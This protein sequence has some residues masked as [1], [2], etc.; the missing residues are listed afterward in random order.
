MEQPPPDSV[1]AA[2]GGEDAGERAELL[3]V[4]EALADTGGW[5]Y[6]ASTDTLRL[7]RG[8]CRIHGFE[9]DATPTIDEVLSTYRPQDRHG[10][11]R[12][13]ERALVTGAG[14][15]EAA[16]VAAG[17][18]DGRPV[19]IRGETVRE[20]GETVR[21]YGAVRDVTDVESRTRT[22][23]NR[24]AKLRA[25]TSAFP[26]L[27]FLLSDR[28]RI[29]E[30]FSGD[31]GTSL[32]FGE[33]EEVIG[34]TIEDR[35][36]EPTGERIRS[37]IDATLETGDTEAIEYKLERSSRTHWFEARLAPVEGHIEGRDAVAMVTRDVTRR[38]AT[39]DRLR[40]RETHLKT[41]Q[42]VADLG[43][44]VRD[45]PGDEIWWSDEVYEIFGRPREAGPIDHETFMAYVH[46]D[47][48][49]YISREWQTALEGGS[50]DVEHR[51]L[52]DGQT[53]WVRERAQV[54]RDEEG[55]PLQ[56]IGIVQDI[57]DQKTYERRLEFQNERLDVFNRILRHDLRNKLNVVHG[58]AGNLER[59][60]PEDVSVEP[61]DRIRAA[62]DDLLSTSATLRD[63]QE[64]FSDRATERTLDVADVVVRV[65]GEYRETY[66]DVT[67][68]ADVRDGLT[69]SCRPTLRVALANLVENAVEYND[70]ADPRVEVAAHATDG[71]VVIEV[72]DNGPGIPESE[73]EHLTEERNRTPL[74]HGSGIGLYAAVWTA[75][76]C[77]GD[78]EFDSSESGTAITLRFPAETDDE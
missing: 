4:T 72:T 53:K 36:P 15:E 64:A 19:R 32:L 43:S 71:A 68:E 76:A 57:T 35:L 27:A 40:Q 56:A 44:W 55:D 21:V 38:K 24:T 46:P 54:R 70:A 16:R 52:V 28:G 65:L 61:V 33:P 30:V 10:L 1:E 23:R 63:L 17:D 20:G 69:V 78:I 59:R 18:G 9:P 25:L 6:D 22:L 34:Q 50:Y 2:V 62:A 73:Y 45:V 60:L 41:A 3:A 13:V 26:D 5:Q 12:A 66:P 7:T 14:F 48:R 75:T 8:A 37:A 51:I 29:L 77:G 67:F 74:N 31:A 11:E 58:Y 47:D 42:A 49:E 39:E